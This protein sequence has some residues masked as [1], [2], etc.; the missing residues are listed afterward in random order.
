[1]KAEIIPVRS[2]S[3]AH[4]LYGFEKPRHPLVSLID[5]RAIKPE[6]RDAA[7]FY[8]MAFYTVSCKEFSGALKYGRSYYDFEE[9][10]L[11]FTAPN[12]VLSAAPDLEMHKGWG[13]FFHP[14]LVHGTGLGHRMQDYS[15]FHYETHEA[16]HV[17]EEERLLL[18]DCADKI[19][20]EY[21]QPIDKH[22]QSVIVSTIELLLNYCSRFY[23]RQFYTR[24]KVNSDIVQ[25]F[26]VLLAAYFAED[27]LIEKGLP[28]V[29]YFATRLHL[30]PNYLSDVLSKSTGKTTQ[31]HIHLQMMEKAKSLLWGTHQ[32]ISEIAYRLGFEHPSHFNKIFKNKTGLSPGQ[33]RNNSNQN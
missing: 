22:T 6:V 31:E 19:R 28:D 13:L 9:G 32:S 26:E 30:S 16:L 14:D 23:D 18:T 1:M 29:K 24:A 8:Q 2:I 7:A 10:S 20:R 3:E 4:A 17:S 12:Q 27:T 33:F 11:M 21:L 15:F 5:F 25:R